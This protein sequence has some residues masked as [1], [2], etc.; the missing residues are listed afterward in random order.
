MKHLTASLLALML[1]ACA[2]PGQNRYGYQDVGHATSVEFGRVVSERQV[3]ITGKN[4]GIGAGA[5]LAR[6]ALAAASTGHG[7]GTLAGLLAGAIV[8]GIAGAAIAQPAAD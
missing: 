5:G 6:G 3:D 2:Q 1:T 7:D 8:A 4:T